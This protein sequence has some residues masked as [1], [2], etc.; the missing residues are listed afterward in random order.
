MSTDTDVIESAAADPVAAPMDLLLKMDATNA[1]V[2]PGGVTMP[3]SPVDLSVVDRDSYLV[4]GM[5]RPGNIC[6]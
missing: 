1:L 2:R 5:R 3:G 4:A 6:L